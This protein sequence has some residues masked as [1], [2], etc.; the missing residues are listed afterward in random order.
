MEFFITI[1]I[2]RYSGTTELE[3]HEYHKNIVN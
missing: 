3:I 2:I 1:P